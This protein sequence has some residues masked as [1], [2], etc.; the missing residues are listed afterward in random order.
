[1]TP[2]LS[3][4]AEFI[5]AGLRPRTPLAKAIT[6]ALAIKIVIVVSMKLFLF[7]GDARP[8]VDDAVM[9]RVL[10]PA[11]SAHRLVPA[12]APALPANAAGALESARTPGG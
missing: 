7:S 12:S 3:S 1:M 9:D 4:L 8:V 10:G 5:K 6:L 2:V 11:G